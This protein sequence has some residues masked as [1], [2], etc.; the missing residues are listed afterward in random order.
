MDLP[1]RNL[2]LPTRSVVYKT[3]KEKSFKRYVD[4]D[5]AS[6]WAQSDADNAENVM[7]RMGYVIAY[8]VCPLLWC[9]KLQA[10][11]SLSTTELEYIALSQ[12]MRNIITFMA[13]MREVKFIFDINTM[14]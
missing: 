14:C 10:E 11:I 6:G 3:N 2:W 9:S 1:D 7:S 4:A 8:V 12:V 5:F 13:L